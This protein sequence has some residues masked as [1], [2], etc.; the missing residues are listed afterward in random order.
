MTKK[1]FLVTLIIVGGLFY[2]GCS[3][4]QQPLYNVQGSSVQ[5]FDGKKLTQAQVEK[6][7]LQAGSQ[8]GWVMKKIKNGVISA[9]LYA[10]KHMALV[11]I[12]Y[13]DS[14]YNIVYKNSENLNYDGSNI[15]KNYNSWVRNLD[16][17]IQINLNS[18]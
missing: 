18:L 9:T 13:T 7:I 12:S 8:R 2:A 3:A 1:L 17:S 10:R 16:N 5:S 6:A 11:E 14:S 4:T 15:H